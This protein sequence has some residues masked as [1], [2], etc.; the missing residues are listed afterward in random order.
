MF[1]LK[2]VFQEKFNIAQETNDLAYIVCSKIELLQVLFYHRKEYMD[3]RDLIECSFTVSV[4]LNTVDR[5]KQER[6]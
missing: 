3:Y 1:K 2:S 6:Y 4:K 5:L